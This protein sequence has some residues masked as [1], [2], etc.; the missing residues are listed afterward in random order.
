[1]KLVTLCG[2]ELKSFIKIPSTV[3]AW[4][5]IARDFETRWNFPNIIGAI[6][7]K[8]VHIFAPAGQALSFF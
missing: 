8:H 6:D 7:G 3:S 4:K 5:Q 2:I 1:M